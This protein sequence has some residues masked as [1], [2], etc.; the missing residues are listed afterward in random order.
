[1]V[2]RQAALAAARVRG[3]GTAPQR[4]RL[5]AWR[6]GRSRRPRC[7][8]RPAGAT[9]RPHS[10]LRPAPPAADRASCDSRRGRAGPR[11]RCAP[12]GPAAAASRAAAALAHSRAPF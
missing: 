4:Y 2:P 9:S 8:L 1:M 6:V 10:V 3:S 11:S 7:A 12:R 5:P